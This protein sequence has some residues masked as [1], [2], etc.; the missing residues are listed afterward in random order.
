MEAFVERFQHC[1]FRWKPSSAASQ[2]GIMYGRLPS[3]LPG[4][5]FEMEGFLRHFPGCNV[6][7][8]FDALGSGLTA[9]AAQ[10]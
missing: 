9:L 1:N 5:E 6:E 8:H 2:T 3:V 4:L 7:I 10:L